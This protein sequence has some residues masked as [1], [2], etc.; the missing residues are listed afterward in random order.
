MTSIKQIESKLPEKHQRVMLREEYECYPHGIWPKG[1]FGE[2]VSIDADIIAV[3]L[4]KHY[5]ALNE[6]DNALHVDAEIARCN[7]W[8][9][10]EYFWR[11]FEI[12]ERGKTGDALSTLVE[13]Y[14]AWNKAQGL[15]LGSADEHCFDE[16]L[17]EEQREWVRDFSERWDVAAN[18][19]DA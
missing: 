16:D 9:L 2:V 4:D 13:E 6:W 15:D 18:G 17:T 5:D 12:D 1:E 19:G 8:T 10:I 14:T 3:K 11:L 7:N